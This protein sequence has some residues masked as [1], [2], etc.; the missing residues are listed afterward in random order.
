MKIFKKIFFTLLTLILLI[1]PISC[2]NNNLVSQNNQDGSFTGSL[3][4]TRV[5]N[6][7]ES[8]VINK[9]TG[10]T[11]DNHYL[12]EKNTV[13][14]Y[15]LYREDFTTH[16]NVYRIDFIF[17]EKAD[18]YYL[19]KLT[20][21]IKAPKS[22]EMFFIITTDYTDD[23]LAVQSETLSANQTSVVNITLNYTTS[24]IQNE[25]NKK[26]SLNFSSGRYTDQSKDILISKKISNFKL[27][28]L[29]KK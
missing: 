13:N 8:V 14:S 9:G 26:L 20:F 3:A 29:P 23:F 21:D 11:E 15:D 12:F 17:N 16:Y 1:L 5:N 6:T 4:S 10:K 7:L 22:E 27:T 28:F 19:I 2:V 25:K 24:D 18:N